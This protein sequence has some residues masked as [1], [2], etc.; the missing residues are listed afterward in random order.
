MTSRC[1]LYVVLRIPIRIEDDDGVRYLQVEAVA[2][3]AN[4]AVNDD[5]E[6][7]IAELGGL[8]PIISCAGS[9][10]VE[11]QAQSSRALRN[12]SVCP[13][14]KEIIHSNDGVQVLEHLAM[15]SNDRVA[16][17]ARRALVNLG[18]GFRK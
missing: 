17:Q 15:S 7:A 8:P 1:G 4:L 13:Q 16:A 3:L 11:L 12:L 18:V 2:A 5:N 10:N 6:I 14:N 9:R